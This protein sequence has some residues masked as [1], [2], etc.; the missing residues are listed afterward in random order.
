MSG[1]FNT[2]Y[3]ANK[4]LM[5]QQTGLHVTGHN[6][7]NI[8][9][10]GYSRQRLELQADVPYHLVGVGKLGTGVK[11]GS[12]IRVV[13]DYVGRQIRNENATL[14]Q[15]Y[16]RAESIDQLEIIFNEPSE[17]GLNTALGEMFSAWNELGKNAELETAKTA[18][19]EKS[20]TV[21]DVINHMYTQMI[22]LKDG[23]KDVLEHDLLDF[24][25]KLDNL[26]K[27]NQQIINSSIVGEI[28]NDLLDQRDVLL[29]DLSS[30]T[31]IG[32]NY[33]EYGRAQVSI[34][35]KELVGFEDKKGELKLD[36]D[37]IKLV[38]E[39]GEEDISNL[40]TS[41]NIKG[42]LESMEEI[43]KTMDD[44]N[45]YIEVMGKAVN[46]IHSDDGKGL[47]FFVFD[48]DDEG[49]FAGT[50]K[51]NPEIVADHS[52]V[53]S[54]KSDSSPEGDGS[55][56]SAISALKDIKLDFNSDPVSFDY[57]PETMSI[58]GVENGSTISGKYNSI[59][60]TV[61]VSKKHVN[62]MIDNQ[63]LLLEQLEARRESS[64]GV[65]L[66]EEVSNI[67]KYQRAYEANARVISALSE[68]LDTLINR[69][70]M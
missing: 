16:A 34:G 61:G 9:T 59:V 19:V 2:L 11:M 5:A 29:V 56:A 28:P 15:Y 37:S 33:D 49:N 35:D 69:T 3:T 50:I 23:A 51:V 43:Q 25:S 63:E 13:N 18:L 57:D 70:G 39:D 62:N 42:N 46:T 58:K 44:F 17:S 26:E 54:K 53:N 7:A 40:I 48:T 60:V 38:G 66:N 24:N 30:N 4:G 67:I 55:R 10:R 65:S 68:M 52:K 41:G 6:I 22:N 36:G 31:N 8:N 12:I 21:T 64:S 45:K 27:L 1:L 32:V 20:K 47:D 14:Q